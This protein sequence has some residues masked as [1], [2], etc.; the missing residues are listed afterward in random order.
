ML[1]TTNGFTVAGGPPSLP[2]RAVMLLVVLYALALGSFAA[3]VWLLAM[4]VRGLY[5]VL[6]GSP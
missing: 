3:A 2:A 6:R 5:A 4:G 1:V